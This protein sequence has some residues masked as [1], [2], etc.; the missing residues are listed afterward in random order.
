MEPRARFS[1]DSDIAV[2]TRD[3]IP[4][5]IADSIWLGGEALIAPACCEVSSPAVYTR[6]EAEL[7]PSWQVI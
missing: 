7:D 1:A 2:N 4:D 3:P 5:A 6:A